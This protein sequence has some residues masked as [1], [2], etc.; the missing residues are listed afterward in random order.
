MIAKPVVVAQTLNF[1]Q[2]FALAGPQQVARALRG[3]SMDTAACSEK[4]REA[5]AQQSTAWQEEYRQLAERW[6]LPH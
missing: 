3:H 1:S 5:V 4:I 2:A 6:E